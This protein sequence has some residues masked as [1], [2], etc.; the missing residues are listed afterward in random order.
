MSAHIYITYSEVFGRKPQESEI[1]AVIASLDKDATFRHLSMINNLLALYPIDFNKKK[2]TEIQ[3][4]LAIDW[5]DK[6]TYEK[7]RRYV[8][9][10]YLTDRPIFHRQQIL[11]LMKK[12]LLGAADDGGLNPDVSLDARK[13]LGKLCLMI[14][15]LTVTAEQEQKTQSDNPYSEE[16]TERVFNELLTQMI[17]VIEL[18]NPPEISASTIRTQELIQ[19]SNSEYPELFEGKTLAAYFE[20]LSGI[21]FERFLQMIMGVYA[22]LITKE[23]KELI[24]KPENFNIRKS[25]YFQNLN[26]SEAEVYEFYKLTSIKY[27]DL[28]LEMENSPLRSSLLPQYDFTV[29]RKYPLFHLSN[30]ILTFTDF[31]FLIEKASFGLYYTILNILQ[32]NNIHP[33]M[34]FQNW[35]YIFEKY[36]N[37]IF[38]GIYPVLSNRFHPNTFYENKQQ[39]EAFDGI[40]EYPTALIVMQY[41][42]GL[43]NAKAKY[44]GDA[45]ILLDEMND[46]FGTKKNK[47]GINQLAINLERL[48]NSDVNKRS[49]IRSL[50]FPNTRVVY[51][52]LIVNELSMGFGLAHWKLRGWFEKAIESKN[53]TAD[54]KVNSL[55]ILTI[56]DLEMLESYLEAEDF[57]LLEFAQFYSTLEYVRFSWFLIK[58][59]WYEPMTSLREVFYRFRKDRNIEFRPNK[60]IQSKFDTF[61]SQFKLSFKDEVMN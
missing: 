3:T 49:K 29:F 38:R 20:S 26:Y 52:I 45:D 33:K 44:S 21:S 58:E 55:M 59:H 41:K 12:V 39:I 18:F 9:D 5:F 51:P 6:D 28:I 50:E 47:S 22:A 1:N 32:E 4:R 30:D 13:I 16:E 46:K 24:D 37:K 25:N 11:L 48:F 27:E 8:E 40:V 53:I 2:F 57:T 54:I 17:S 7:L 31:T 43:L 36:V 61:M 10:V 56:E 42:G 19:I 34:F 14:S 60:K 15:D 35:G 23:L